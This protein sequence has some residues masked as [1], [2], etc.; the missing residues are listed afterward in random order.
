MKKGKSNK[1]I[2]NKIG[3]KN[4]LKWVENSEKILKI[5]KNGNTIYTKNAL[6]IE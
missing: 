1:K 3:Q 5:L 2:Y 6:K 4:P